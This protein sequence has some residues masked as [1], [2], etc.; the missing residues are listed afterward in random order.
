M[1]GNVVVLEGLDGGLG[2]S[3]PD[4]LKE[5]MSIYCD[6]GQKVLKVD[7]PELNTALKNV[8]LALRDLFQQVQ[9][10]HLEFVTTQAVH[11]DFG[12]TDAD[13]HT[14]GEFLGLFASAGNIKK[15]CGKVSKITNASEALFAA[16]EAAGAA[17][18]LPSLLDKVKAAYSKTSPKGGQSEKKGLKQSVPEAL[19]QNKSKFKLPPAIDKAVVWVKKNPVKAG[20]G[21]LFALLI[22]AAALAPEPKN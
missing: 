11:L 21:G 12:L 9:S 8:R 2:G 7:W 1:A 18:K 17:T 5:A 6:W 15:I 4:L 20:A 14:I 22:V 16:V 13:M 19:K 10:D 3:A